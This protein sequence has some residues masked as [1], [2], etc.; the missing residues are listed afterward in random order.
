MVI[1]ESYSTAVILCIITMLCWGSWAN[2]MK[3]TGRNWVFQ[4]YYWDYSLG[5][6]IF[7]LLL[8]LTL[9]S[10][11]T[12]GRSFAHDISQA[13]WKYIFYALLAGAVFNLANVLLVTAIGIA[14]MAIAFPIGIGLALVLGVV[15]GYITKPAGNPFLIF[16]GL[17][18]VV[19]A[20]I[21]DGIA[22][23]KIPGE[24]KK[25]V[26]KG[27]VISILA[28]GF[29]G[30]FYPILV[31]SISTNWIEPETGK[32]T[33]YTA[34]V[35]FSLGLF[36]SSFLWNYY[37][38]RKPLSGNAVAFADYFNRGSVKDHLV[39]ILGGLIW[40]TGFSLMTLAADKAGAAI[41]YGLG[42]GATMIAVIWGIFIWKEFGS[43]PKSANKLLAI[44]FVFYLLGLSLLVIA[45]L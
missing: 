8:A 38:M 40:C 41:S 39:G 14:G 45:K 12:A 28:G 25:S 24:G 35:F 19:I 10:M 20:I 5:V 18:A 16:A 9:G 31:L 32:L 30:F 23:S 17:V 34:I 42:Q 4:L 6:L 26:K 11:G 29:M 27:I 3:L 37:F 7:S 44:M 22:Y 15:F 13:D 1:I 33:P 43:A 2:T 21:M 36:L